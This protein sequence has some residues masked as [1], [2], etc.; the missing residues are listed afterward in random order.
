MGRLVW[1]R[2]AGRAVFAIRQKIE[3]W[4][5]GLLARG[6]RHETFIGTLIKALSARQALRQL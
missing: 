5:P 3:R 6:Y 1:G 2:V 4:A